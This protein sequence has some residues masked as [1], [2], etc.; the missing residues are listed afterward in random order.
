MA[1]VPLLS[2]NFYTFGACQV[3]YVLPF[4]EKVVITQCL[5]GFQANQHRNSISLEWWG[6][7]AIG[8]GPRTA[9]NSRPGRM[10]SHFFIYLRIVPEYLVLQAFVKDKI[11]S[12][13]LK[14]LLLIVNPSSSHHA[15]NFCNR[16]NCT[17][18]IH[19]LFQGNG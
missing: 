6:D 1:A 5:L 2:T 18:C 12:K 15:C 10:M 11:F 7:A 4:L 9:K 3:S 8:E 19:C 17:W 14:P 13:S 16:C